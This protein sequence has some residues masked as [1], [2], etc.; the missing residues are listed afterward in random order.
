VER[1]STAAQPAASQAEA[2]LRDLS[3]AVQAL[4]RETTALAKRL[5][6]ATD[7]GALEIR[8]TAQELRASAEILSRAADRLQDPRAL[9]FG[10]SPAQLGPGERLR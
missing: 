10:P 5:D 8:A 6:Q 3:R 4:E 1:V 7:S 9:I 2:T